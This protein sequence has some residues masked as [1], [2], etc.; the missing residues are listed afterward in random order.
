MSG[1]GGGVIFVSEYFEG[2]KRLRMDK[3]SANSNSKMLRKTER[4]Y[5]LK[6]LYRGGVNS[7]T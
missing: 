3:N 1:E 2:Q 4:G 6:Q 7:P 5:Q